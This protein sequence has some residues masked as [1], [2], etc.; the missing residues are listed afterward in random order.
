MF[1]GAFRSQGRVGGARGEELGKRGVGRKSHLGFV[2]GS[3]AR[4]PA[5]MQDGQDA[6]LVKVVSYIS[7]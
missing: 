7:R 2:P 5:E 3:R 1:S 4:S 6:S